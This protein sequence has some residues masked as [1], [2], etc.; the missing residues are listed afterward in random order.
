MARS[1][2][3]DLVVVT[4]YGKTKQWDRRAAMDFFE[5][6]I[7]CCEGSE[8]DRYVNIYFQLK[9]GAK[10]ASDEIGRW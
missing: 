5:E 3:I 4:C 1:K 9:S 7:L 2:K 10:E 6:G 8:R